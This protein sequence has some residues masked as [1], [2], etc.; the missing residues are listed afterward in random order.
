MRTKRTLHIELSAADV[1]KIVTDHVS[2]LMYN[3]DY[4]I[5]MVT[6]DDNYPWPDVHFRGVHEDDKGK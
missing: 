4:E 1:E 5:D 3:Q 6:L 2:D